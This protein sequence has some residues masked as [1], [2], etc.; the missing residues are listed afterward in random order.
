M[1]EK[2]V[3]CGITATPPNKEIRKT[4]IGATESVTW[5]YEKETIDAVQKLKDE[6][7]KIVCV[8]QVESST[9]FTDFVP[10][11]GEKYALILGN[12]VSGVQQSVV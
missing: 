7:Y 2:L 4:A 3:L 5:E 12:E 11:K 1:I 6:G 10:E 9:D 8:E